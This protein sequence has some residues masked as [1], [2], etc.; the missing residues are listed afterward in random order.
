MRDTM[1]FLGE[2]LQK[3][4]ARHKQALNPN[5]NVVIAHVGLSCL[6][7]HVQFG[8]RSLSSAFFRVK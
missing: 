4:L 7:E 6:V 1:D 8:D 3:V 2:I 5:I